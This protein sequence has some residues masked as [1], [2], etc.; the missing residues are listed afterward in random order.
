MSSKLS[1]KKNAIPLSTSARKNEVDFWKKSILFFAVVGIVLFIMSISS[2][3]VERYASGNNL[4]YE[5]HNLFTTPVYIVTVS[6]LFLASAFWLIFARFIKKK[7]E[8]LQY[9]SSLNTFLIMLYVVFF[10]LFFGARMVYGTSECTFL[11][12]V[13]VALA[14]IYYVSKMY[15]PDF[16]TYTVETFILALLLYRY[17]YVYTLP[18]IIGKILLIIAFAAVG[19][20]LTNSFKKYTSRAVNNKK[21]TALCYPYWISLV[22]WSVFMFIKIHNPVGAAVLNLATMLTILFVQYIVFAI[23]YTIRLIRE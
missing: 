5:L 19:V 16:L 1:P 20:V 13:T 11:L 21:I 15:H 7:D 2:S 4:A 3:L 23:V 12:A 8:S 10:S 22:L 6:A 18:G 9:F 14:V 17:W